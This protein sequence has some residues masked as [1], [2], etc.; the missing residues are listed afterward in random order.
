MTQEKRKRKKSQYKHKEDFNAKLATEGI[1][2]REFCNRYNL[3]YNS[4]IGGLSKGNVS[5]KINSAILDY[6]HDNSH[7]FEEQA[8]LSVARNVSKSLYNLLVDENNM[9]IVLSGNDIDSLSVIVNDMIMGI[10]ETVPIQRSIIENSNTGEFVAYIVTEKKWK[11]MLLVNYYKYVE[12]GWVTNEGNEGFV[13]A[14]QSI[15]KS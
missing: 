6:L 10:P 11:D 1:T 3:N 2:K 9:Y 4:L 8:L 12:N 5:Q 7:N 13:T 14:T 15:N